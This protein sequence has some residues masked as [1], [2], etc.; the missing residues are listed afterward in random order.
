MCSPWHNP[1]LFINY[2]INL[3]PSIESNL[4]NC[5]DMHVDIYRKL[6][7]YILFKKQIYIR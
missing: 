6:I 5:L 4:V 3:S 2:Y 7:L 1:Q